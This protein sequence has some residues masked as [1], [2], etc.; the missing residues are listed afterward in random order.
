MSLKINQVNGL[1]ANYKKKVNTEI[2]RGDTI[3]TDSVDMQK[4]FHQH[5]AKC[6]KNKKFL[7]RK[8]TNI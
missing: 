6:I 8:Q 4:V 2:T 7:W 5:Y 3:T 1:H